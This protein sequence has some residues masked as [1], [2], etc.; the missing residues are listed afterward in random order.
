MKTFKWLYHLSHR[1]CDPLVKWK[2]KQLTNSPTKFSQFLLSPGLGSLF[3]RNE[4]NRNEYNRNE[5]NRNYEAEELDEPELSSSNGANQKREKSK[6]FVAWGGKR[7]ASP[8]KQSAQQRAN[9]NGYLAATNSLNT[10]KRGEY[11]KVH[12]E[13]FLCN[14]CRFLKFSSATSASLPF[15]RET[16]LSFVGW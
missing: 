8:A 14:L 15:S 12:F 11:L 5:Y 13:F 7:S 9:I 16:W 4:Y 10:I 3:K 6:S 1:F 2:T